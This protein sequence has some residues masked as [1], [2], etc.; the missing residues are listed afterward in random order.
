[1]SIFNLPY[2]LRHIVL[3]LISFVSTMIVFKPILRV[4]LKGKIMDNPGFRKLQKH[5]VPVLGGVAVYFGIIVGLCFYK[6]MIEHTTLFPIIGVMTVMLYLGFLDDSL[7]IKPTT[8][9]VL[10]IISAL[11]LIFGMKCYICNFQGMWGIDILSAPVGILLSVITFC[12]IVNAINMIDGIDGLS[13]AFCMLIL[14]CFGIY[15]FIANDFSLSALA[16]IGVGALLPFFMHNVFGYTTK[17]FIGDGG[18]LMMG[19][20]ISAMVYAILSAEEPHGEIDLGANFSR[21]A[22]ALAVLS[23]PIADT[24]RVMFR[25][26]FHGKSPFSPDKTHLHHFFVAAGYSYISITIVEITLDILAICSF[27]LTWHLGGS[28][29]LQL[30]VVIGVAALSNILPA[31]LLTKSVERNDGIFG[32]VKRAGAHSHVE[33]RGLWL[34]IQNL[35]DNKFEIPQN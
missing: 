11:T 10:E 23:V 1:M 33:R 24:L 31:F 25:R 30:Y 7:S 13:S 14:G 15:F 35:I 17:M 12:G 18:T 16:A 29:E 26:I 8:R 19:A 20:V 22:F 21:I 3:F 32:L 6:T 34:R 9:L 2:S 5:P 4:A 27:L 28:L